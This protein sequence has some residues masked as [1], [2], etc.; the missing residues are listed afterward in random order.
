MGIL[1]H[2]ELN[3]SSAIGVDLQLCAHISENAHT[4]TYR[5]KDME[6]FRWVKSALYD[7][8][9][10]WYQEFLVDLRF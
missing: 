9:E 4:L 10:F 3:E 5:M 6:V 7:Q 1:I 2:E 8:I